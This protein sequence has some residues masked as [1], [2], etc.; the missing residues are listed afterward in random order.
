MPTPAAGFLVGEQSSSSGA[1]WDVVAPIA[2]G[3]DFASATTLTITRGTRLQ[4]MIGWGA[5]MTDTSAY[6][7]ISL[8][9]ASTRAAFLEA[10]WGVTGAGWTVGR[11]T[12][13]SADYSVRSYSYDNVT[14]DFDLAAVDHTVSYDTEHVIPVVT[15]ARAVVKARTG[16]EMT[17][18]AS[19]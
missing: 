12:L 5:A 9:N 17:L 7:V 11:I 8:M 19:P 3:A 1:Q 10:G 15:G 4:T 13:N 18:F 14:D 6:N 2:W 16:G